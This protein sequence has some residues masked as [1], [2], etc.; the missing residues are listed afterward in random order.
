M[1]RALVPD[2]SRSDRALS[3]VRVWMRRSFA[4]DVDVVLRR[5]SGFL[6]RERR[7]VLL[8]ALLVTVVGTYFSVHLY[9]N[10]RSEIE[11]LLPENAPSVIAAKL[12]GPQLHNVNHLSIVLEGSDP[13]AM[14]RFADDLVRRLNALPS[15]FIETVDYRVDQEEA[16]LQRFGLLFLSVED[17]KRILERVKARIAWEK[18]NANP[19][20][21]MIDDPRAPPPP[22]DFRDIEAKYS[23]HDGDLKRFRKGYFQ[24]PDGKL[25]AILVR[26]PESVT[27]YAQNR[28]LL[29][30]IKAEIERLKPQSYDPK[31]KIGFDGEVGSVVEEQE[32]L[33]ADL[34]SSTVIVIVFVLLALW[35]Y[36]RRWSAIAAIFG[37]LVVGCAVTFGISYFLVGHLNANT[38]FL[39]SIVVGNGINVAIII[40]ARYVE[41]R[42]GGLPVDIAIHVAL[43]R[44]LAATFVAAFASGL[45]YLSLAVTNFRGFRHFGLIGG[46]GMAVCWVSAVLLLPPMLS[47]IE[48]W[49]DLRVTD[50]PRK[51]PI[52]SRIVD[53][54]QRRR[55]GI[56]VASV[57]SLV[58]VAVAM[59]SY[60]G[61]LIE[62]D[63][64]K[65][66]AKKSQTNGSIYWAHRLDQ[67]FNA[68][69]TPVVIVGE[70]P[71]DLDRVVATLDRR[72]REI[73]DLDPFREVRTIRST[74]PEHQEEKIPLLRELR[75]TL[76]QARLE[77]LSPEQR[78]RVE[79]FRPPEDIR[80]LTLNDLPR[81]IKLPLTER[82]GRA[83]RIGLAFPRKVGILSSH[84]TEQMTDLV[85]GSIADS[86]AQ[87]MAVGQGLLFADITSA[88]LKDGPIATGIAF[89][90]VWFLVLLVFRRLR[91]SI[92]V[93]S[94]LLLGVAWLVGIGAAA[95]VRINFLNFVVLPITFGIGVD[96]AVNIVQRYRLEGRG[97]LPRVLR[98]TGGA[99]ALCSTTTIIGYF[100]LFAADNQALAGFGLLAALGELSCITAALIALPAFLL[101]SKS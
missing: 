42:R 91:P 94:G 15:S 72:R 13:D 81:S 23:Q 38:A 85:R 20:L 5:L 17:L 37:S 99:V 65:L 49:R 41:E 12:L 7:P 35:I 9:A 64:T 1:G 56:R 53:F 67:I 101:E 66:R 73:G 86:G 52:T 44:T 90:A 45:A 74:I 3:V 18:Q 19:L 40:V 26:P 43:R 96:Y 93:F 100:S 98:E 77:L 92:T 95:R 69:L 57:L 87:A 21:S 50:S 84:E 4:Q 83:G 31:L 68:Y 47:A 36:F 61:E 24:T 16:L 11:E 82:N 80:P 39:G 6:I 22:L 33:V 97:S 27:G 78:Q 46:L 70:T 34:A 8:L 30:G 89:L 62:Y 63:M 71:T 75:A 25:L 60:R 14:D 88:I 54:V 28:A 76:T 10:L 79:K 32:A 29:D 2:E 51:T 59:A 55:F 58:G 48:S